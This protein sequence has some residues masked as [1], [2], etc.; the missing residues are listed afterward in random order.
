MTQAYMP[1]KG[2]IE[3]LALCDSPGDCAVVVDAQTD[4]GTSL[5]AFALRHSFDP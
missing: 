4:K 1:D 2:S 5:T 3:F